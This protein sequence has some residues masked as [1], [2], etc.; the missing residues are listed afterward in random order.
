MKI[1]KA[2]LDAL[3][4]S[5][6]RPD[7][8]TRKQLAAHL[9]LDPT[10]LTR[11][12][13]TRD[14]LGN[15]RYP[16]VPDR[17]V[18]RILRLFDLRAE[19]LD[20]GDDEFRS[21][22]FGLAL[23]R[24]RARGD[25]PSTLSRMEKAAARK[26]TIPV[27]PQPGSIGKPAV[28]LFIVL[29]SAGLAWLTGSGG[30][31]RAVSS[32]DAPAPVTPQCWTGFSASL[33]S[34]DEEDPSDPCHYA[35]LFHNALS[36]LKAGNESGRF[37]ESAAM[38]DYMIFLSRNL[39]RRRQ[40]QRATLNIELGRSELARRN[41]VTAL[42]YFQAAD[43]SF[44]AA[45]ELHAKTK[46]DIAAYSAIAVYGDKPWRYARRSYEQ[47]LG[48]DPAWSRDST[49]G[50]ELQR[51]G[52]RS[53][54]LA[55]SELENGNL[56]SAL[57][58][59]QAALQAD[60]R[61]LGERHYSMASNWLVQSRV[62]TLQGRFAEARASAERALALDSSL[63]GERHPRV[64]QDNMVLTLL[65]LREGDIRLARQHYE[66]VS[67]FFDEHIADSHAGSEMNRMLREGLEGLAVAGEPGDGADGSPF[68]QDAWGNLNQAFA[69]DNPYLPRRYAERLRRE[70]TK[71]R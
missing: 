66:P 3:L 31:G 9:G 27:P 45:P 17:H 21:H 70:A 58:H 7:I 19:H 14:R 53:R 69:L 13:A 25:S 20:A 43:K 10:S 16:V 38:E 57:S 1:T 6:L 64:A 34:F 71:R 2:K 8:K 46:R 61:A 35:K 23:E 18:V 11:W 59:I 32:P 29:A 15:P 68:D 36:Q 39:D 63:F 52:E 22:C 48:A 54:E 67:A 41:Y 4:R 37:Q 40:Q 33:G 42:E 24:A 5:G 12:F 65:A 56:D 26:L 55:L 60:E 30:D 62:L 51:N 49:A 50:E 44:A 47:L 28:I